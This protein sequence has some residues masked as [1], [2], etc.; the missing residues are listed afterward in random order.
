MNI[1]K[2]AIAGY[3]VL[4]AFMSAVR[5][6]TP[7]TAGTF[8][9]PD[10]NHV[11]IQDRRY[12]LTGIEAPMPGEKCHLRGKIRDCGIFARAALLDL[13]AG[14]TLVCRSTGDSAYR[15][16][17]DGYDLSEGMAYTGWAV[18]RP[19]AVRRYRS[20]MREARRKKRGFWR[21]SFI[22]QWTPYFPR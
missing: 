22:R 10:G 7:V 13:T 1:S 8:R 4:T 19:G 9:I 6:E 16:R 21:G 14:A 20:V 17:A 5:A 18:T 12:R 2:H 11:I 3:L 15:C